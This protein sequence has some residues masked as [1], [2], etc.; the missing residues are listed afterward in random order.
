MTKTTK[1]QDVTVKEMRKQLKEVMNREIANI[2]ELFELLTPPEKMNAL[3]KLMPYVFP[4][5]DSVSPKIDEPC[6]PLKLPSSQI[7]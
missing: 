2:G 7:I 1:Q 5:V 3:L 4:R 6:K